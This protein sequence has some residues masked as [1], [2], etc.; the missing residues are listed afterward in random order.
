MMPELAGLKAVSLGERHTLESVM[1]GISAH[2]R[3]WR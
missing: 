2:A 1:L 3:I